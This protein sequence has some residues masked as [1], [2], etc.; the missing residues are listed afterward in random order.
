MNVIRHTDPA[1]AQR[2]RDLTAPSSLFD[3]LI[4]ERASG[5]LQAVRE[6]G[7]RAVIEFTERFDGAKLSPEQLPVTQAELLSA[8]LR[9]DETCGRL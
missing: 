6:N 3:P 8:S 9:A 4:E 7:D 1:F 2:L 5:I